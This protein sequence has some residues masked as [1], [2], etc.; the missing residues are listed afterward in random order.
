MR[1]I[2]NSFTTFVGNRRHM[3]QKATTPVTETKPK[4]TIT[5]ADD[6]QEQLKQLIAE[7]E[8]IQPVFQQL[9]N[10]IESIIKTIIAQGGY[11]A[12][13]IKDL[14]LDKENWTLN[15]TA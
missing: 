13:E 11:K 15:F 9:N 3:K 6:V 12:S 10:T 2:F 4:T 14:S 5:I 1:N 7:V 8:K